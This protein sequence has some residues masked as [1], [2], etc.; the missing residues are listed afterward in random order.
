MADYPAGL[1]V[2][3]AGSNYSHIEYAQYTLCCLVLANDIL[4]PSTCL[5]PARGVQMSESTRIHVMLGCSW[6]VFT[7]PTSKIDNLCPRATAQL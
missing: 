6:T 5:Q 1:P 3:P 7:T 2:N 4:L